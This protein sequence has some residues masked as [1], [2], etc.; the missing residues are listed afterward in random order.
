MKQK[1]WKHEA[2]FSKNMIAF[3]KV[4]IFLGRQAKTFLSQS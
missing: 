2:Y 4:S 1:I 3:S